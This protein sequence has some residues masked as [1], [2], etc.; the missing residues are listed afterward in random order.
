MGISP[1]EP[2][3]N[4]ANLTVMATQRATSVRPLSI[5]EKMVAPPGCYDQPCDSI[6]W[7]SSLT[8]SA[9]CLRASSSSEERSN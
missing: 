7:T 6:T 5:S 4:G 1:D 3:G 8:A 2:S 9:E